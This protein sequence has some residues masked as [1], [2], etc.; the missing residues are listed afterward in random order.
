MKFDI[1][2]LLSGKYTKWL[3]LAG[4]AVLLF[5]ILHQFFN[6]FFF[7]NVIDFNEG[8]SAVETTQN[9]ADTEKELQKSALFGEYLPPNMDESSIKQTMLN[10]K[11]VGIMYADKIENSQ[12]IIRSAGGEDK[13]YHLGDKIPGGAIIKRILADGI[14]L[15][16]QGALERLSFPKNELK[17]EPPARPLIE[18]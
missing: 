12:V 8:T 13:N 16:Y 1:N 15:E 2:D 10:V 17:F 11:L 5:L 6:L 14:L 7:R 9:K 18:E 4:C 3:L